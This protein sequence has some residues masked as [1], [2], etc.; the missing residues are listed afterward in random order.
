[1]G[2]VWTGNWQM[3][4]FREFRL[5]VVERSSERPFI[6]DADTDWT[7]GYRDE[8]SKRHRGGRN[9][10]FC[11]GHVASVDPTKLRRMVHP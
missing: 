10:L 11:D 8:P 1:M 6:G 9:V 4:M 2:A 7:L 3:G 5:D